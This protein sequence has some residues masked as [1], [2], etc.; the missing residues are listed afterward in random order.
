M[1]KSHERASGVSLRELFPRAEFLGAPDIL[2]RSCCSDSRRI[3]PGDLF[4][5]LP[6]VQADGHEYA[7]EAVA[8]GAA[9]MLVERFVPAS[10]LPQCVVPDVRVAYGSICQALAGFP[11]RRLRTVGITG[12]NGKTTTTCLTQGILA[13]AGAQVGTIGTLGI[14]DGYELHSSLH[15]TPPAAVLAHWMEAMVAADCTH[16]V[17]EVSSHALSQRRVAG[18]EFD[19]VCFTNIRRDHLDFHGSLLNYRR[20]KSR[21]LEHLSSD[22][23]VVINNDEP[24]VVEIGTEVFGPLITVGISR[25]ADV[26][27]QVVERHASEQ[28]FLLTAGEQTVPVRTAMIGDHHIYNCLGAAAL[29]IACGVDLTTIARGLESVGH[30]PGRLERVEC[31]QSFSVFVDY[32]HTPD[33]LAAALMALR[34]VTEGRVICVFG[35]GGERDPRK[36]PLMGAAVERNADLAIITT[37]NPR[38]EAPQ[39]I[40]REI[41]EGFN[42]PSR[43]EQIPDRAAAIR[44][45]LSEAKPGDSVLI[46]GKGHEDYQIVGSQRFVFD[47]RQI[48]RDFLYQL[49]PGDVPVWARS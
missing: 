47:D 40:A 18:V 34:P 26:T 14:F 6:G 7:R 4:V 31:G 41:L 12:T 44:W 46:A 19:A 30:V 24:E 49:A 45:A 25:D 37:D 1:V 13:Q 39:A 42:R 10:G 5:A 48:A 16:L 22:G 2:V 33:A 32:A 9:A 17:M 27:A 43:V 36:R 29:G 23:V 8:R 35:A 3:Q 38:S 11:S 15:T 20:A 21:L 28:V